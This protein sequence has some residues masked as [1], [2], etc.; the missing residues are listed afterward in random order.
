MSVTVGPCIKGSAASHQGEPP[1]SLAMSASRGQKASSSSERYR[2]PQRP[3]ALLWHLQPTAMP[4][5]QR[6]SRTLPSPK[7]LECIP[8][9]AIRRLQGAS[10]PRRRAN[11]WLTRPRGRCLARH[12]PWVPEPV[13]QSYIDMPADA[14]IC[15]DQVHPAESEL[16]MLGH[17]RLH[18]TTTHTP[19]P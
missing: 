4:S 11:A 9:G 12:H 8:R 19:N 5:P 13:Q 2:S 18:V 16:A 6:P 10:C 15:Q 17:G 3:A 7:P 1:A 14:A